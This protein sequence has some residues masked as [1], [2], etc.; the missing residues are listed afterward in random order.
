MLRSTWTCA[1]RWAAVAALALPLLGCDVLQEVSVRLVDFDTSNVEGISLWR[2][3]SATGSWERRY[4]IHFG[5]PYVQDGVEYIDYALIG[6]DGTELDR[7][8]T[9]VLRDASFPDGAELS[10]WFFVYDG[11]GTYKVAAFNAQGESPLSST[12]LVMDGA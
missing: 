9:P 7:V 3:D 4:E 6:A 11:P 2:L 1:L 5:A 8:P 12:T 10:L